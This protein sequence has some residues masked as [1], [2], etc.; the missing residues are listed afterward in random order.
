[1]LR[2]TFCTLQD[3]SQHRINV[4]SQ[5]IKVSLAVLI[6]SYTILGK[7]QAAE[8]GYSNYIPGTYGDFAAGMAPTTPWTIRNDVYYYNADIE[9]TFRNGKPEIGTELTMK[10]NLTTLVY[11]PDI[12]VF[13]AQYAIGTV[14]PILSTEFEANIETNNGSFFASEDVTDIGDITIVPAIFFW[15]S[16]NFQFTLGEYIVTPSASYSL[17]EPLNP[18]LNYWTF[19]TNFT[20]NY[21]DFE[22]GQDYSINI[23]YTYNTE[24]SDTNYQTGNELHIDYMINQFVSETL[25]FGIH[26]F[27]L[28][29]V[30]ADSGSGA[31]LGSYK[32]RAA[33]VGPAVLW[34]SSISELP[35]SFIFKWLHEYKAENRIEGNHVFASFALAF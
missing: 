3:S 22:T 20:A 8:G 9:K 14:L 34:S 5:L 19:D 23:G 7:V 2:N 33:G 18:S 13:G 24:N 4:F 26:G 10:V 35:V 16:G 1:M 17:S 31:A 11:K 29:Q 30:T 27:Y 32:G 6:I 25:A 21:L 28:K 12:E 15:N